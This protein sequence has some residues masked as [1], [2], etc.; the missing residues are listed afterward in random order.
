MGCVN[1]VICQVIRDAALLLS[2]R[3]L[4]VTFMMQ[5]L[6]ALCLFEGRGCS[7]KICDQMPTLLTGAL[8][9]DCANGDM[10]TITKDRAQY[11]EA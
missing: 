10:F 9:D 3:K 2:I 4:G 1:Q 6:L 11:C 5:D 8:A 7:L